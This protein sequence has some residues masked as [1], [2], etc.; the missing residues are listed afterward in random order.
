MIDLQY[1]LFKNLNKLLKY[2]IRLII[3]YIIIRYFHSLVSKIVQ[4]TH[5][6][7]YIIQTKIS[8]EPECILQ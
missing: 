6:I 8:N 4:S 1:F 2:I 5:A 3:K 7:K